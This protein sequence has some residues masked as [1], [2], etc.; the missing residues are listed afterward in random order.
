MTPAIATDARPGEPALSLSKGSTAERQPSPE[1]LGNQSRR[2]SERRRCGTVSL[3]AKPGDP[4]FR[5]LVL[6][7]FSTEFGSIQPPKKPIKP[8]AEGNR[9]WSASLP[10]GMSFLLARFSAADPDVL[11]FPRPDPDPDPA[12]DP[13]PTPV[14]APGLPT[15]P[16]PTPLPVF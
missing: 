5:R 8:S 14:P 15:D 3:G 12:P 1:G 7:M 2:G 10:T 16:L 13:D 11:P 6:E 9:F 4:Q